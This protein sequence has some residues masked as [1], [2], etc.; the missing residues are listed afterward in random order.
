MEDQNPEVK[1]SNTEAKNPNPGVENPCG[2]S[3]HGIKRLPK[4]TPGSGPSWIFPA[5]FPTLSTGREPDPTL[6]RAWDLGS[7]FPSPS[8]LGC[9]KIPPFPRKPFPQDHFPRVYLSRRPGPA[10]QS[11]LQSLIKFWEAPA[12]VSV[13]HQAPAGPNGPLPVIPCPW[14]SWKTIKGC[15]CLRLLPIPGMRS[16][17]RRRMG[18]A[19]TESLGIMEFFGWESWNFLGGKGP[20]IP[21]TPP[22]S[23]GR[24]TSQYPRFS[25]IS[26]RASS[27]C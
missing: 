22:L 2:M 25:Q 15:P 13:F 14:I 8:S 21:S 12:A 16:C 24:D 11:C 26:S 19:G 7:R 4:T 5:H 20:Q 10:Q 23:M 3:G 9:P 1:D 17:S 6:G 27:P 18:R